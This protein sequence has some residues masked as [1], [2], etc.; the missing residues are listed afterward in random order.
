VL[1]PITEQPGAVIGPYKLLEQI[2]EGGFGVVFRA[3]QM[4]PVRR[5]VAVKVLKPG[6]DTR[7]VVAR[8]EAE[9]QALAI[10]DHPNI[11]KVH[12][13][14]ATASGRPYF[15][16]ELVHG[17][18]ITMYCDDHQ[19]SLKQ[20]LD[21]FLR[22]CEA[23]QHAH[24]KGV[25]HRDLKPS[26]VLVGD[27]DDKP[28]LKVIDFGVAKAMGQ[29][30]SEKTIFTSGGQMIG[31]PLYMS[32]EQAG[33]NGIDVDT[34]SDVY[35][36]GVLLYELI[37]GTTPIDKGR[38][39]KAGYDEIRRII[40][41]EE[42]PKPSTRLRKDEGGRMKDEFKRVDRSWFWSFSSFILHPSSF[43]ELDWI[44][45]KALEKD[46]NRRYESASGFAR[47]VQRYLADEPVL[48]CPPSAW[49]RFRKF[50]R[51][52]KGRVLAASFLLVA[53]VGGITGTTA[54]LIRARIAEADASRKADEKTE[55]LTEAKAN[56]EDA[57][58]AVDRLLT[59]LADERLADVPQMESIRRELLQ[60]AL[61]FY[62][63]FLARKSDDPVIRR[64][65]AGCYWRVGSIY[66]WLGQDRDANEAFRKAIAMMEELGA[67]SSRDP[68]QRFELIWTRIDYSYFSK[69]DECVRQR[70]RAVE[71]AESLLAD[72]PDL[73]G[74]RADWVSVR[75]KLAQALIDSQPDEAEGIL[76]EA[77]RLVD[78]HELLGQT[79]S[80]L[81]YLYRS[82]QRWD[83]AAQHFLQ[84]LKHRE[85]GFA[86]TPEA[87]WPRRALGI[88]LNDLAWL[89]AANQQL[90]EAEEYQRRA[91]PVFDRL[92]R[93]F[94][95]GPHYRK[96]VAE[97][98]FQHAGMLKQLGKV[99][100]AEDAYRRAADVYEK[101][102]ADFPAIPAFR[103]SAFDQRTGLIRFLFQGG[104]PLEAQEMLGKATMEFQKLPGDFRDL[105][106]RCRFDLGVQQ[107][108][109]G[110]TEAA[111]CNL[112]QAVE[113]WT[114][115]AADVPT[116]P[117]YLVHAVNAVLY[118]F[119]QLLQETGRATEAEQFLA[120]AIPEWEKLARDDHE[121]HRNALAR[122]TELWARILFDLGKRQQA[123]QIVAKMVE[124]WPKNAHALIARGKIRFAL[125]QPEKAL[126]DFE[127]AI[128]LAP[129]DGFAPCWL[130]E[131]S[132]VHATLKHDDKAL[133]DLTEATERWP[134]H[135][136]ARMSR[137]HFYRYRNRW[138]EAIADYDKA[139]DLNPQRWECWHFRAEV[140]TRVQ[141]WDRAI[142][143]ET[144]AIELNKK[145]WH[146]WHTRGVAYAGRKEWA[147]AIDDQT[148]ATKLGPTVWGSFHQRGLCH[149][150]LT[151]WDRAI[152]DYDKAIALA[153][154]DACLHHEFAW[155][156]AHCP[157]EKARNSQRA[158]QLA[159]R[160]VGLDPQNGAFRGTLGSAL[161]R[162]GDWKAAIEEL[163]ESI[164]RRQ[165]GA[166]ML[167][168]T[169]ALERLD[170]DAEARGWYDKAIEWIA[171]NAPKDDEMRRFK[172][173][174]RALLKLKD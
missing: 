72:F 67:A 106:A 3:E 62:Q 63:K 126:E 161:Y 49:Y 84:A 34:R 1:D 109:S 143:D 105:L 158:V 146:L 134:K 138:R 2:G 50:V 64:E 82:K 35:S 132:N 76:Q 95:T 52:N 99:Q 9:R 74:L 43:Q 151:N 16:M 140:H 101:L 125:G 69:T 13:G 29:Q 152:E 129:N 86:E 60:D 147:K 75:I 41:E 40:C 118:P 65:A 42:P 107:Y 51:R 38:L 122:A 112:R 81:G 8:F 37:T 113:L 54:G 94:P 119:P 6:M 127:K 66:F 115:L 73:P 91:I 155:L 55:A 103:Q 22:A 169:M 24:Q 19:L 4:H 79:H 142:A 89:L 139:V 59:R 44:V 136:D 167:F 61:K 124:R 123:E 18:P 21:L 31:T 12:D 174:A 96:D 7:Q 46:R 110:Q 58:A 150:Q 153:A 133:A 135:W 92:A 165:H 148:T 78:D 71:V 87:P 157:D 10:M 160:A 77:L 30:L 116:E 159:R 57:M 111:E 137:G 88:A 26:N 104:R 5:K 130:V 85:K 131:R 172:D 28:V 83:E 36:L 97:A 68:E 163:N 25:I 23:V 98:Q 168:L 117:V 56:L 144:K 15:V 48:A 154:N 20:R 128:G 162:G 121:E 145:D 102:A 33:G 14:G 39:Q 11:A 173:E 114:N 47:D 164:K 27:R 108:Q 53:L 80:N 45:M 17:V 70:R 100:D 170:Q 120:R 141:E 32:P 156:L 149:A 90:A 93:D 166:D 171:K